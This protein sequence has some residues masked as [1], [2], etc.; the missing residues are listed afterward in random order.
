MDN[1]MRT[2]TFLHLN[3]VLVISVAGIFQVIHFDSSMSIKGF[4]FCCIRVGMLSC[5]YDS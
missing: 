4:H 1:A 3:F 5:Y 2:S